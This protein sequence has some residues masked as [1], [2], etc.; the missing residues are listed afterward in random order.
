MSTV[1]VVGAGP[2]GLTMAA[3]L[4]RYRVPVRIV[5]KA[6]A[7][8]DKSK[9]LV[10]W[11]RSVEL[12]ARMGC[13]EGFI[14][15][16][17]KATHARISAGGRDL[18][19]IGLEGIASPYPYA[20]MIP[21]SETE[22]LME[23]HLSACGIAVE[24]QVE[25][26]GFEAGPESVTATLRHPDGRQETVES[27]WLIGCDGAHSTVRH[28]LG[29]GFEGDTLPSQWILADV[30]VH[31]ANARQDEIATYWH[32]EGVLALF[33]IEPGRYR[34]VADVGENIGDKPAPTLAEVQA[35]LDA[36]GPGGLTVSS[37]IWLSNFRIN[38]R[39][40]ADYRGGASLSRR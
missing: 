2:V 28:S 36:R 4:A 8:T 10:L 22:R 12:I 20:L 30:H 32:S 34:V 31:G 5:D 19:E 27:A 7:R 25:L 39:K 14:A 15:A 18:A 17:M 37:P 21:Q 40:V 11:S 29:L 6:A 1:L 23:E 35:V 38:E 13:V 26:V 33:P 9:A 24:R 16:G 3:E